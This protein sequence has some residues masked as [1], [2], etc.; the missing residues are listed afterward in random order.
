M[1]KYLVYTDA[2]CKG[3]NPKSRTDN[4]YTSWLEKYIEVFNIAKRKCVAGIIDAG[5]LLDIPAVSDTIVDDILDI[6]EDKGIP[7][8]ALWGNHCEIGHN[9][10]NSSA[11]SL[12]HMFRRC[13]LLKELDTLQDSTYIIKGFEYYHEV[14]KDAKEKGMMMENPEQKEGDKTIPF[15]VGV[16]HVM[17]TPEPFF[18]DALYVLPEEIKTNADLMICGHYHHPWQKKV[19][20]TQFV[21]IGCLGRANIDM[22]DIEPSVLLLDT[23][24]RSWEIIK[25]KS[26]KKGT[27]VFDLTKKEEIKNNERELEEF[28]SQLKDFKAQ[29]LDLVGIVL[30]I[31]EQNSIEKKVTDSILKKLGE[32]K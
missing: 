12:G 3:I 16:A 31:A 13:K 7:V 14:E 22:Y 15:K 10:E 20:K 19:G 4:Y 11:T 9:K 29:E 1:A 27:D 6:I 24:K 17:I 2:H 23:D 5:D 26:A 32:V 21:N 8:W 18:K 25:L 30:K 28:I